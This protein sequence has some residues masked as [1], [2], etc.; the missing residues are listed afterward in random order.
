MSVFVTSVKHN[1]NFRPSQDLSYLQ[2]VVDLPITIEIDFNYQEIV[3]SN[4]DNIITLKPDASVVNLQDNTGVIYTETPG[5]FDR[6]FVGDDIGINLAGVYTY[7]KV[8]EVID[9]QTLRTDYAGATFPLVDGQDYVFNSTPFAGLRYLYNLSDSTSFNSLIDA[10]EQKLQLQSLDVTNTSNQSMVFSGAK[11]YQ[12]G[13]ALVKGNG[14][15]G[16]IGGAVNGEF[17]KQP[18]TITHTTVITPTFLVDQY[19]DLTNGVKPDY[20]YAQDCLSYIAKIELGRDLNNPNGLQTETAATNLSSTG[21]YDENFNGNPTNYTLKSLVIKDGATVITQ[22]E[23]NK[24]ITFEITIENTTDSP[25][26]NTNTQYMVGFNYLPSTDAQVE[27]NGFDQVR[28]FAIDTKLNTLGNGSAN[29]D[30]FGNDL[31]IIKTVTSTFVSADEMLV[32]LVINTGVDADAILQQDGLYRYKLY[33]ITENHALSAGVSDMVNVL[34]NVND[35]FIQQF[36]PNLVQLVDTNFIQHPYTDKADATT[37]SDLGTFPVDDLVANIDFHIDFT[38]IDPTE[39]VKILS[40][41]TELILDDSTQEIVLE[42]SGALNMSTFAIV[43]GQAQNI[44]FAK[45]RVFKI[46]EGIRKEITLTR[47]IASDSGDDLYYNYQYPFMLRWEYWESLNLVTIPADLFDPTEPNDGLNQYWQRLIT[48]GAWE[49]KLKTTFTLEQNGVSFE[50]VFTEDIADT[51]EYDGNTDW[52]N[53]SLKSYDVTSGLEIINGGVK[54]ITNF[55]YVRIEAE[56]D[57]VSGGLP[58]VNNVGVVFWIET[59]EVGGISDIRRASS[60]YDSSVDSWFKSID[61]SLR[62]IITKVG[63]IYTAK[64]LID[65]V[66]L[67]AN[68]KFTIYARMYD[69]YNM[70]AKQFQNGDDFEFQNGDLYEFD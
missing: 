29:G 9:G 17:E 7:Y 46:P 12:I 3:Y 50:Q 45:D 52:A 40:V 51:T 8:I 28:N 41:Q 30:N 24:D 15:V 48:I 56:F 10:E 31:Q 53:N 6:F 1:N 37:G 57:K 35:F 21:W 60:F 32:T 20:F 18:F 69:F 70:D 13:S 68:K 38:G 59:F 19:T 47:D 34:V 16:G 2:G 49:L 11:S 63:S 33:L 65:Y 58:S 62:P 66:K 22:P 25:F 43:G 61:S 55:D 67:P 14:G 4:L 23:F 26:S 54:Y 44:T 42:D 5:A 64:I 27:K 39:E 36:D